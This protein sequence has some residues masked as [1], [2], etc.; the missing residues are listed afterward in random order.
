MMAFSFAK[1]MPGIFQF[2]IGVQPAN[3][4]TISTAAG[5]PILICK[6]AVSLALKT[7]L[8]SGRPHYKRE[9]QIAC[10]SGY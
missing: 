3:L 2:S 6:F 10:P 4:R 5:Q 7:A 1:K 8:H 9:W